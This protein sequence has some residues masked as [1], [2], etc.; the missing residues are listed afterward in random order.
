MSRQSRLLEMV[1]DI[2]NPNENDPYY[3]FTRHKDWFDGHSW[4]SGLFPFGDSKNQE[5]S[6]EAINA[7][8]GLYLLGE[9]LGDDQLSNWGRL[10]LAMEIRSVQKYWHI[11]TTSDIYP[12]PFS[13][14]TIVG[15]LWSEKVDYQTF[16]GS[17]VEYIHC[18]QML[19]FTPIT[20]ES[21]SASWVEEEYN[22]VST[23]LNRT[24][25]VISDAWKGFVLMDLAIIDKQDAWQ[26]IQSLQFYD[27]GNSQTNTMYWVATRPT[28]N[29][30]RK[31]KIT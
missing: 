24:D 18:I 4:A 11:S 16:F 30:R 14:N 25:P 29:K 6:S 21:L 5:S 27:N 1:R 2:G 20:E 8:Y 17:N 13:D 9:S 31:I 3:P 23:A 26:E 12:A 15:V 7:Y 10:L 19:P 22:V 28:G